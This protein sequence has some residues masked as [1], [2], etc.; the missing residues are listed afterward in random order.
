VREVGSSRP[1]LRPDLGFSVQEFRG[2]RCCVI[3][4]SHSGQFHRI[5]LREYYFIR[6]LDGT[7]TVE[8]AQSKMAGESREDALSE[9]EVTSVLKWILE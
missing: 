6:L 3:E 7:R 9:H 8:E 2:E 4:D 5:G 1:R